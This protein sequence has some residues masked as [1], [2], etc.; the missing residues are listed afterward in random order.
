[1]IRAILRPNF[2]G[3]AASRLRPDPSP[4]RERRAASPSNTKRRSTMP[5]PPQAGD[6]SLRFAGRE[7]LAGAAALALRCLVL[8]RH[9]GA[10]AC[11]LGA[12]KAARSRFVHQAVRVEGRAERAVMLS[13]LFIPRS[14]SARAPPSP[15]LLRRGRALP[16]RAGDPLHPGCPQRKGD[17]GQH[18]LSQARAVHPH[19]RARRAGRSR[20]PGPTSHRRALRPRPRQGRRAARSLC[21]RERCRPVLDRR[22]ARS[23]FS[24][25]SRAFAVHA[26]DDVLV[27]SA[28]AGVEPRAAYADLSPSWR[29]GA[30]RLTAATSPASSPPPAPGMGAL[31]SSMLGMNRRIAP[32]GWAC[33][34]P[35]AAALTPLQI[36]DFAEVGACLLRPSSNCWISI[37]RERR[38]QSDCPTSGFSRN[39]IDFHLRTVSWACACHPRRSRRTTRQRA[40]PMP[41]QTLGRYRVRADGPIKSV[42]DGDVPARKPSTS[43]NPFAKP[44]TFSSRYSRSQGLITYMK[45]SVLP[46]FLI[47]A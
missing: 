41:R 17:P 34:D 4:W 24:D 25:S 19:G 35:P 6:G 20:S 21:P 47:A 42:H 29:R 27:I 1:M 2:D 14:R 23:R 11:S 32:P 30:S 28:R 40:R 33:P 39:T 5:R 44:H 46:C 10:G 37:S 15:D 43:A 3:A 9:D 31:C 18:P 38:P 13:D 7:L 22:V 16:H 8:A 36:R 12:Q 26:S 45:V